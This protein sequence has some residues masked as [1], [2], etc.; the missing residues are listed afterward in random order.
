MKRIRLLNF[1]RIADLRGVSEEWVESG[2][3]TPK[4]LHQ[5]LG[6]PIRI[7]DLR[8]AVNHEFASADSPLK[9]GDVVAFLPP[10]AGG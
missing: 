8:V 1:A 3:D 5:E 9:D 7:T 6:L 2:A 4:Q 10:F